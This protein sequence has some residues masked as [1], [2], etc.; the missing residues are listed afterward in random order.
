MHEMKDW[1]I[2]SVT[3]RPQTREDIIAAHGEA[4][5]AVLDELVAEKILI[6]K[7]F[8]GKIFYRITNDGSTASQK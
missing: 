5:G 4:A 6:G 7:E 8:D 1:I 2:A 3:V